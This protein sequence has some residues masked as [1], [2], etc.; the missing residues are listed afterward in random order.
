M[1]I[2]IQLLEGYFRNVA[3]VE[4]HLSTPGARKLFKK[5]CDELEQE[6]K[7]EYDNTPIE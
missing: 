6:I 3:I 1:F 5:F 2:R 4:R 7:K